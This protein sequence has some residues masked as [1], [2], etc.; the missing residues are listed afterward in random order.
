MWFGGNQ[1][2]RDFLE[3]YCLN[4]DGWQLVRYRTTAAAYYRRWLMSQALGQEFNDAAPDY[5][6]G[7]KEMPKNILKK[8]ET[9]SNNYGSDNFDNYN[10]YN[11]RSAG[12][13]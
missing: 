12:S 13:S 10:Q 1:K 2:F 11:Q 9:S 5:N 7:R 3:G 6:E 8:Q 4:D